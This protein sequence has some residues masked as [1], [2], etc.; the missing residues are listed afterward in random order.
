MNAR[1]KRAS[2]LVDVAARAL[3]SARARVADAKRAVIEAEAEAKRNETAWVSSAVGFA[4][5]VADSGELS[6]Q[7]AHL[8]TLR[9]RADQ[10]SKLLEKARSDERASADML[11]EAARD[12][13]KL[14]LWRDR[15][16]EAER[17]QNVRSDQRQT[18]ELAARAVRGRS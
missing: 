13:R 16:A 1:M 12:C 2:R 11:L 6:L 5:G 10:A 3:T 7:A 17:E 8:R 15:L 9:L 14:E 18:D 4:K